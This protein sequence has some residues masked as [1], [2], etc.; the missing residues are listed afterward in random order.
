MHFLFSLPLEQIILCVLVMFAEMF[1]EYWGSLQPA[2]SFVASLI[3]AD[4]SAL[5]HCFFCEDDDAVSGLTTSVFPETWLFA[6]SN[7]LLPFFATCTFSFSTSDGCCVWKLS[8][9]SSQSFKCG[10]VNA[11]ED[12]KGFRKI[13]TGYLLVMSI[14]SMQLLCIIIAPSCSSFMMGHTKTTSPPH[15]KV[16]SCSVLNCHILLWSKRRNNAALTCERWFIM[17]SHNTLTFSRHIF[18]VFASTQLLFSSLPFETRNLLLNQEMQIWPSSFL[19]YF[20]WNDD[21]D[22]L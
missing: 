10:A 22:D 7:W 13:L 21:D 16:F 4:L 6:A 3:P 15:F 17:Q 1:M 2:V 20:I 18:S 9:L 11:F 19:F 12:M 14:K 8:Q 5:F